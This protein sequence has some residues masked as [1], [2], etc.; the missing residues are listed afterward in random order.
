MAAPG[1]L[2]DIVPDVVGSVSA[3]PASPGLSWL[4][5]NVKSAS[6]NIFNY[7]VDAAKAIAK[8]KVDHEVLRAAQFGAFDPN[9]PRAPS[10]AVTP[11]AP[12]PPLADGTPSP[13]YA[14][15]SLSDR[16]LLIGGA[17]VIGLL[18]VIMLSR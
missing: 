18:A 12:I 1:S 14:A 13:A 17:A 8:G 9:T 6:S 5:D 7:T 10:V 16:N 15:Q 3:P 11:R 2:V 4:F